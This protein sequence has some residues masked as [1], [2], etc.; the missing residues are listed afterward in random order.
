MHEHDSEHDG[1]P[2]EP[3]RLPGRRRR[4]QVVVAVV[5]VATVAALVAAGA[6]VLLTRER[7]PSHP[8]EWDPSVAELVSF[9]EKEKG[10]SFEHPVWVV[11]LDEPAFEERLEV[12][13]ELSDEER[14]DMERAEAVFRALGLHGGSG[15]LIDQVNTLTHRRDRGLLRP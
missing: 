5:A 13:D 4:R 11:H 2:T 9:V 14:E 12:D 15:S 1:G 8:S 3:T 7:G 6:V 10:A